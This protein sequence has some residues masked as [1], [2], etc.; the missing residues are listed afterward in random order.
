MAL[1]IVEKSD[2]KG[3]SPGD[4]TKDESIIEYGKILCDLSGK[5]ALSVRFNA[6]FE[7]KRLG[8]A[9]AIKWISKG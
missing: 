5:T 1:L 4:K 9:D 6:L 2:V 3:F 7:L 8:G